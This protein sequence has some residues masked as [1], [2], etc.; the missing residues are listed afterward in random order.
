MNRYS[1]GAVDTNGGTGSQEPSIREASRGHPRAGVVCN[2]GDQFAHGDSTTM[3]DSITTTGC[4]GHR[5]GESD[6]LETVE[7]RAKRFMSEVVLSHNDLLAGNV[8]HAEGWD[9]VQVRKRSVL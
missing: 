7:E 5:T 2:G 3:K 1:D 8:L 9:R 4:N 6:G